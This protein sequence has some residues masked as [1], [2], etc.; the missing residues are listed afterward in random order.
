MTPNKYKL[1]EAPKTKLLVA[2]IGEK[3]LAAPQPNCIVE[4]DCYTF[5]T[6]PP[7]QIHSVDC[8][9]GRENRLLGG[10]FIF[11]YPHAFRPI[12]AFAA[13]TG[14]L[15]LN[16]PLLGAISYTVSNTTATL[17]ACMGNAQPWR[18]FYACHLCSVG[19]RH[20]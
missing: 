10:F 1:Q 8:C 4:E 15:Y 6:T 13:L 9:S 17:S 18:F 2:S 19:G 5:L 11:V 3:A 12:A 14:H 7:L 16:L 20:A